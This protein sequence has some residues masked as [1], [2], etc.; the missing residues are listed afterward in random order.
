VLPA[1]VD[2]RLAPGCVAIPTGG[3]HQAF[4]RWA[5]GFGVNAMELLPGRAAP[6]TGAS[7]LCATRVRVTRAGG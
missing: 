6:D 2:P 7:L 1:H 4:G 3:G 5:R